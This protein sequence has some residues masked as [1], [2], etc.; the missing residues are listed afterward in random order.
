MDIKSRLWRPDNP[1]KGAIL[2]ITLFLFLLSVIKSGYYTIAYGGTDLRSISIASKMLDSGSTAYFYRW[3]PG[4]PEKYIDPNVPRTSVSNAVTV[5][6]GS[7]YFLSLF[8]SL[9][10]LALRITWTVVQYILVL[11]ILCF[12]YFQKSDSPDR[13]RVIAVVGV[14][15]FLCTPIWFLNIERGQIY[16]VFAFLF[17]LIY[18]LYGSSTSWKN[19]LAGVVIA[20][21]IY[22]RPNFAVLLIPMLVARNWNVLTGW[23]SATLVLAIHAYRNQGLWKGYF[24]VVNEFANI[25]RTQAPVDHIQYSYPPIIEGVKNLTKYKSDFVCGGIDS[26]SVLINH[27]IGPQRI[28]FYICLLLLVMATLVFIF[29]KQLVR[30][31]AADT[32][33]FGFLLYV[34][35]ECIMPTSRSA[36]NLILWIFPVLLFMQRPRLSNLMLVLLITGLFFI[37]G[38]PFYFTFMNDIGEGLLICALLYYLQFYSRSRLL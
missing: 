38:A 26:L 21:A 4:Q 14:L 28:Y 30:A 32:L 27:L 31:D 8:S 3:S 19:F 20:L 23:L 15:F 13:R 33:L 7:L 24:S 2:A 34:V 35:A 37:N 9:P 11:Y 29:K 6:P 36:Y 12:F 16:V 22:C 18:Q 17:T 25:R 10:Y 5:A 1:A